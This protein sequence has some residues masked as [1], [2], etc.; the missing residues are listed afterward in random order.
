LKL[1]K[2]RNRKRVA[3]FG[4]YMLVDER[5]DAVA[6]SQPVAFS[7]TLAAAENYLLDRACFIGGH[8]IIAVGSQKHP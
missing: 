1:R 5:N 8:R 2:T 6:G 7:L 3:D 4:G